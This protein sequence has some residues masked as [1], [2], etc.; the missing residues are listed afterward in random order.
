MYD[1]KDGVLITDH[2]CLRT[3]RHSQS[4]PQPGT[5][6]GSSRPGWSSSRDSTAASA[7]ATLCAASTVGCERRSPIADCAEDDALECGIVLQVETEHTVHV[8]QEHGSELVL[9]HVPARQL[10]LYPNLGEADLV[11]LGAWAGVWCGGPIRH[12]AAQ[13]RSCTSTCSTI[14]C[15]RAAPAAASLTPHAPLSTALAAGSSRARPL[16]ARSCAI[17][18]DGAGALYQSFY[19]HAGFPPRQVADGTAAAL[20]AQGQD[21]RAPG[22]GRGALRV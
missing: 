5:R 18:R 8:Q 1:E 4:R 20:A 11:V 10:Q 9:D 7:P 3:R 6:R 14:S 12:S 17:R 13:A 2:G 19:L 16:A 15:S 21:P 22:D